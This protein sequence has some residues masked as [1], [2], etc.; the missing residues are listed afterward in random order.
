MRLL[1]ECG[2]WLRPPSDCST[3]RRLQLQRPACCSLHLLLHARCPVCPFYRSPG[4]LCCS[5]G[6][7]SLTCDRLGHGLTLGPASHGDDAEAVAEFEDRSSLVPPARALQPRAASSPRDVPW[8]RT[9]LQALQ[10]LERTHRHPAP[11]PRQRARARPAGGSRRPSRSDQ[12]LQESVAVP[13]GPHASRGKPARRCREPQERTK[14]PGRT[15]P[16][17]PIKRLAHGLVRQPHA[18]QPTTRTRGARGNGCT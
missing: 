18:H 6:P 10:A 9:A 13:A 7:N 17:S 4:P 11:A 2:T 3:L 14:A 16:R 8:C 12:L 5:T 1:P 15:Y